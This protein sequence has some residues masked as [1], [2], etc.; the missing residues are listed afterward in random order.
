MEKMISYC[1][2]DCNGCPA[3][4]ATAHDDDELRRKTA[5]Q[6]CKDYGADIKPE[7]VNCVGCVPTTGQHIGHWDECEMRKCG[8]EKAVEN[9]A[10]CDEFACEKLTKFFEAVPSAKATLEKIRK[11]RG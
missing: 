11:S 2:L 5:E 10:Y 9:C 3:Y 6:W 7:D 1:G 8:Q 4:I